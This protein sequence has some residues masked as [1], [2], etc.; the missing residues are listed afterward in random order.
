L[1]LEERGSSQE[2]KIVTSPNP[3]KEGEIGLHQPPTRKGKR[4]LPE[5]YKEGKKCL[6]T[7]FKRGGNNSR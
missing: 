7:L 1:S 3:P 5:S 2:E 4:P 6:P